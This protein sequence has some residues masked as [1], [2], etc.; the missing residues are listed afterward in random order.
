MRFKLEVGDP[1]SCQFRHS[2]QATTSF[3]DVFVCEV[4][5]LFSNVEFLAV[6]DC[7]L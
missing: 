6:V 1:P 3:A 7:P 5:M 2:F 4:V